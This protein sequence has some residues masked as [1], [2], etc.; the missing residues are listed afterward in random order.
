ME[1]IIQHETQTVRG[2][3]PKYMSIDEALLYAKNNQLIKEFQYNRRV[4]S[5]YFYKS[6]ISRNRFGMQIV[7]LIL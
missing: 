7:G 2:G 5:V 1:V 4:G 3:K 6:Y